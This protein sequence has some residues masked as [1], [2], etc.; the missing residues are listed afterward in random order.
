MT[1]I[2][3]AAF[4]RPAA[5]YGSGTTAGTTGVPTATA[6]PLGRLVENIANDDARHKPG[7]IRMIEKYTVS[8]NACVM[9]VLCVCH[10]ET[11]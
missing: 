2:F 3:F 1:C 7:E 4:D 5:I 6:K 9:N 11:Y 10:I 8:R